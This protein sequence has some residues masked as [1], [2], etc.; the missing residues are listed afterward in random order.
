MSDEI[1]EY[2]K[3]HRNDPYNFVRDSSDED[4][5]IAMLTDLLKDDPSWITRKNENGATLLFRA[6]DAATLRVV[7]FLLDH[8]ANVNA[9]TKN[10]NTP[11]KL[12]HERATWK[13]YSEIIALL[14][15]YNRSK[16]G[17]SF[18]KILMWIIFIV[19]VLFAIYKFFLK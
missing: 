12:A 11:L 17:R 8:G 14:E 10:G 19:A 5:T 18:L 6:V 7:Q 15:A 16:S 4:K 1:I 3:E 9:A 13:G 2:L